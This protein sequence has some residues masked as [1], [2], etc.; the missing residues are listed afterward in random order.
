MTPQLW[1]APG[2]ELDLKELKRPSAPPSAT[3]KKK[4]VAAEKKKQTAPSKKIVQTT[5]KKK[6]VLPKLVATE[7]APQPVSPSELAL[8][9]GDPCQLAERM[10]I[11]VAQTVPVEGTLNGLN[12]KPV[13]AVKSGGL[14]T[15]I[16]CGLAP[17]EAYTFTRLLEEHQVYLLNIN[18]I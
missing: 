10:A 7:T 17:A 4:V 9:G 2:F 18:E 1:A 5:K 6:T 12:L 14:T 11:A 13:I 8:K 3:V 15:V 16:T